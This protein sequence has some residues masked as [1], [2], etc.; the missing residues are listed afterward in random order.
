[1]RVLVIAP[2]LAPSEERARHTASLVAAL[3][4]T[5]AEVEV[6]DRRRGGGRFTSRAASA[7][8]AVQ[9][10]RRRRSADAMVVVADAI[11]EQP[12][13]RLGRAGHLLT[14]AAWSAV[15]R[16]APNAR[17]F[18]EHASAGGRTTRMLWR[19]ASRIA[20]PTAAVRDRIVAAG[21]PA[22]RVA[23]PATPP[24][25]TQWDRGW[26]AVADRASAMDAVRDRAGRDRSAARAALEEFAE[27]LV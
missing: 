5:G 14:C 1:M 27:T 3:A 16:T 10:W 2:Y 4:H 13:G 26:D 8:A 12:G 23:A 25:V 9:A 22:A 18:V 15:F 7:V 11:L 20:V 6:L 24:A 19:S 17:L 21:A